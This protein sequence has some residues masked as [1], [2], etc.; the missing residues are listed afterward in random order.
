M[1]SVA[2]RFMPAVGLNLACVPFAE[3]VS[4]TML[5]LL[6]CLVEEKF[7]VK[8]LS[9]DLPTGGLETRKLEIKEFTSCQSTLKLVNT[10]LTFSG[11]TRSSPL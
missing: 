4:N 9:V 5:I 11:S 7:K 6:G 1:K 2:M 8:L 3:I 10:S